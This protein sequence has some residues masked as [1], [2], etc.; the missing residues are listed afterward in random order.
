MTTANIKTILSKDI[1][2]VWDIV[3]SLENYSWR[4]DLKKIEVLENEKG[5]I[6]HTKD[7]YSTRFI[8]TVFEPTQRYEFDIENE[9]ITGHWVGLFSSQNGCTVIDFTENIQVKS[10]L[11]KP[12]AKMYL[13]KQQAA[14]VRD[15]EQHLR[16]T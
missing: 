8:I 14:Y 5:F 10:I 12:F 15:L 7:G 6:E 1:Q 4:S 16:S 13:K 9:N 11:M 3:T 2:T